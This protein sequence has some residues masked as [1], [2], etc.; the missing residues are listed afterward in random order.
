MHKP[1]CHAQFAFVDF[2]LYPVRKALLVQV[3]MSLAGAHQIKLA[4]TL[5]WNRSVF[6]LVHS[7]VSFMTY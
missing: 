7:Y 6:T 1:S 2:F 3:R 4:K 5:E